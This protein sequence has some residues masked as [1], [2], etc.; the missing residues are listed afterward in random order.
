MCLCDTINEIIRTFAAWDSKFCAANF[1]IDA[2]SLIHSMK[3]ILSLAVAMTVT[4][5][6][7]AQIWIDVTENYVKNPNFDN[8]IQG[9]IDGFGSAAQNHGFQS[10]SYTNGDADRKSVV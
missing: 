10:G 6:S 3:R 8:N 4:V 5:A 9:W 1:N 2:N 7:T